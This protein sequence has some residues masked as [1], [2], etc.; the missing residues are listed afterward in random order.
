MEKSN[1]KTITPVFE[2]L[3]HFFT[4]LTGGYLTND[5]MIKYDIYYNLSFSCFMMGVAMLAYT[6]AQLFN[7]ASSNSNVNVE[8]S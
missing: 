3:N 4:G 7:K 5:Y 2:S 6:M 8:V 1:E